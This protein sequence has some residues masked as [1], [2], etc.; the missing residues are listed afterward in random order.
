LTTF[1]LQISVI[2]KDFRYLTLNQHIPSAR[3]SI[4]SSGRFCMPP[5]GFEICPAD[6]D[7]VTVCQQYAW[8]AQALSFAD[9]S[10]YCTCAAADKLGH[11]MAIQMR[12][13]SNP[14]V[15]FGSGNVYLESRGN[16]VAF[17]SMYADHPVFAQCGFDVLLR[18][19]CAT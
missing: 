9:G 17:N 16:A 13:S 15:R 5:P 2:Y 19:P 14:G 18:R 10:A 1:R 8:Q 7:S 4:N 6:E 11:S 3:N 12:L